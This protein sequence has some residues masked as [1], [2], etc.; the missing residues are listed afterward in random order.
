MRTHP[1]SHTR[2]KVRPQSKPSCTLIVPTLTLLIVL[3]FYQIGLRN[4]LDGNLADAI[5][6]MTVAGTKDP[7]NDKYAF[8]LGAVYYCTSKDA[9][10]QELALK[11]FKKAFKLNPR[12]Q[13]AV[14]HMGLAQLELGQYSAALNSFT[15]TID[16]NPGHADAHNSIG[17]VHYKTSTNDQDQ[18]AISAAKPSSRQLAKLDTA[19]ESFTKA[20]TLDE[21]HAKAHSNLGSALLDRA[22]SKEGVVEAL[23]LLQ[24][25]VELAPQVSE[26]HYNLA[27]A[28]KRAGDVHAS[29]AH[30]KTAI[31]IGPATGEMWNN[32]GLSLTDAQDFQGAEEAFS[33][34]IKLIPSRAEFHSNLAVS[35]LKRNNRPAAIAAYENA[36]VVAPSNEDLHVQLA[37]LY[38]EDG[39]AAAALDKLK[40]ALDINPQNPEIYKQLGVQSAHQRK[41]SEAIAYFKKSLT[42]AK[43]DPETLTYLGA[44][45]KEEGQVEE[46]EAQF[47][48]ALKLDPGAI[49][50]LQNLG[51]LYSEQH[52]FKEA[53]ELFRKLALQRPTNPDVRMHLGFLLQQ[54]HNLHEALKEFEHAV[55]LKDDDWMYHYNY[56]LALGQAGENEKSEHHMARAQQLNPEVFKQLNQLTEE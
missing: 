31:A 13:E 46:A 50:P 17:W 35:H 22:T 1:K 29:V 25:A 56:A 54:Q 14:Y 43:D 45:L 3:D 20:L 27:T 33:E 15:K 37:V 47:K 16:L 19:I 51:A 38:R 23:P 10:T 49:E 41:W 36:I 24:K 28:L 7:R 40:R 44:T 21:K 18:S 39:Q 5:G 42:F 9:A 12:S 2:P 52:K 8:A 48:R 53:L 55:K 30:F 6:N 32:Y 26:V 34:A 4:Y 11:Q